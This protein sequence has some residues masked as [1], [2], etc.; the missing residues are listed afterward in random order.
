M[1]TFRKYF[2]LIAQEYD[3]ATGAPG[4]WTP[5]D[6]VFEEIKNVITKELRILDIGI[7]T[8]QSIEKIYE[9]RLYKEIHGVDASPNMLKICKEKYPDIKLTEI[10]S[11]KDLADISEKFE[12]IIGCGTFEFI[13]DI[14][15][16]FQI[17][18]N[19]QKKGDHLVFTYEPIIRF[20][21]I[22]D[23]RKSLT[24]SDESSKLY[25]KDFYTYR[26]SPKEVYDILKENNY[27]VK[28]DSEFVSYRKRDV[29]IIY[30]VILAIAD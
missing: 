10:N 1:N 13:E 25:V 5:P 7:G 19:K 4:A 26:P 16:L 2:D 29:N 8:G 20:H 23:E 3:Q 27:T 21:S 12:V 9:S 17:I 15:G 24:V 22:Q 14:K 28:V 18:K 6:V 30:H 11:L